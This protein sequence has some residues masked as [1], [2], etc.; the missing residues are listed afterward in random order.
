M[1]SVTTVRITE[2]N[3]GSAAVMPAQ[4]KQQEAVVVDSAVMKLA[5]RQ[6][7]TLP[8]CPPQHICPC[9]TYTRKEKTFFELDWVNPL[10]VRLSFYKC[11]SAHS[12][13][14]TQI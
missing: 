7:V 6:T 12:A 5:L 10:E 2:H 11:L 14:S 13:N 3:R 1:P 9:C 8:L 4:G